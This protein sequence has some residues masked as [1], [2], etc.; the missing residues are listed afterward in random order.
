M[1]KLEEKRLQSDGGDSVTPPPL[2]RDPREFPF[3]LL[4][5]AP[6]VFEGVS[7]FSWFGS[8][9]E[10]VE[11]LR[12]GVWPAIMLDDEQKQACR[13]VFETILSDSGDL[14]PDIL[15]RLGQAQDQLIVVWAGTFQGVLDGSEDLVLDFLR[16]T[17]EMVG[18]MGLLCS[19]DGL[20]QL[21]GHYR[22]CITDG[23]KV[24]AWE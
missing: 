20:I 4:L 3:G 9:A 12:H 19:P 10:A 7:G 22:W 11:Y 14:S 23:K 18:D 13:E 8:E 21:M 16:N 17:A 15:E 2:D 6:G 24:L 1:A 5:V